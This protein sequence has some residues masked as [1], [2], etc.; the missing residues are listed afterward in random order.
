MNKTL[1]TLLAACTLAAG[2]MPAKAQ[3]E[4][5]AEK[6]VFAN[7]PSWVLSDYV[8]W[9]LLD[10][11][12]SGDVWITYKAGNVFQR[13]INV[14]EQPTETHVYFNQE[15]PLKSNGVAW[16]YVPYTQTPVRLRGTLSNGGATSADPLSLNRPLPL[17]YKGNSDDVFDYAQIRAV[18]EDVKIFREYIER[19]PVTLH[20]G[21]NF[22]AEYHGGDDPAPI[23]DKATV[24][25]QLGH[26]LH[27]ASSDISKLSV[28]L[29]GGSTLILS[30]SVTLRSLT[31]KNGATLDLSA[32]QLEDVLKRFKTTL[33]VEAGDKETT[34]IFP[35]NMNAGEVYYLLNRMAPNYISRIKARTATQP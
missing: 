13:H 7:T 22:S 9:E 1:I 3:I 20:L 16:G 18:P 6:Q 21:M 27:D 34:I 26:L 15:R 35:A 31:L 5:E 24:Y 33:T 12:A 32:M 2:T 29:Y 8:L 25:V 17:D 14:V 19:R 10:Y 11:M 28:I 30:E 4:V 23:V